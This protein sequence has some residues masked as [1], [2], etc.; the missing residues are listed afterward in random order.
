MQSV[1]A[2]GKKRDRTFDIARGLGM[3][4]IIMGHTFTNG[5]FKPYAFT[6]GAVIHAVSL[7]AFAANLP[8][9]FVVSGYFYRE[10]RLP[11]VIKG[12]VNTLLVPYVAANAIWL[13]I[14]L[15]FNFTNLKTGLLS[16][17]FGFGS[18][19]MTIHN[20]FVPPIGALWFLI[21]LF[22]ATIIFQIVMKIKIWPLR[23]I[24]IVIMFS[25]GAWLGTQQPL[26]WSIAAVL[27]SQIYLYFGMLWANAMKR[28]YL[29]AKLVKIVLGFIGLGFWVLSAR[30][31][32]YWL[33]IGVANN[34]ILATLGG[35][36]SSLML[37]M[38]GQLFATNKFGVL[39]SDVGRYSILVLIVHV[40][41]MPLFDR[42]VVHFVPLLRVH[43]NIFLVIA[44]FFVL[45]VVFDVVLAMV[46]RRVPVVEMMFLKRAFP[47][48]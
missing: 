4:L 14:N 32:A 38:V 36:G 2:S 19:G 25:I 26:P 31:G 7:M 41:E 17:L 13:V 3:I 9:F 35:I 40:L 5:A 30:S 24:A 48:K 8:I 18:V 43:M 45:R 22:L 44:V 47:L 23:T 28:V 15:A 20:T 6:T 39:P 33:N 34:V 29:N 37:I 46:L 42:I 21:A 11:D 16:I 12:G 1:E 10:K 27:Q